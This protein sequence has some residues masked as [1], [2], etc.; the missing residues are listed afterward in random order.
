MFTM[1]SSVFMFLGIF[2]FNVRSCQR[3][4]NFFM[5]FVFVDYT[6]VKSASSDRQ[7]GC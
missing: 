4:I 5:R 2:A 3:Q 6:R 7:A 1:Y